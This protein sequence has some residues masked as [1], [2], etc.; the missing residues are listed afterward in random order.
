MSLIRLP[1]AGQKNVL[2][3]DILRQFISVKVKHYLLHPL[4]Y[5][6]VL[7]GVGVIHH[8]V[9][10]VFGLLPH[11]AKTQVPILEERRLVQKLVYH[12]P[13]NYLRPRFVVLRRRRRLSALRRPA[14]PL[15]RLF[16]QLRAY[17]PQP[18]QPSLPAYRLNVVPRCPSDG[19][20]RFPLLFVTSQEVKRQRPRV[21]NGVLQLPYLVPLVYPDCVR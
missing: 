12:V 1:N 8:V 21:F 13:L 20:K 9:Q 19:F 11:L 17:L 7:R 10:Q 3:T 15:R 2:D 5:G 4:V 6:V 14:L 18:A 16:H